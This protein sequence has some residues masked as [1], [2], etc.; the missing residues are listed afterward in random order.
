[1]QTTDLNKRLLFF[2]TSGKNKEKLN[3]IG[4]LMILHQIFISEALTKCI[5]HPMQAAL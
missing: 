2:D 1:M 3:L 4:G 5:G